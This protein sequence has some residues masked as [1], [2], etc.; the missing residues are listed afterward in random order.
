MPTFLERAKR[1]PLAESRS[2]SAVM[3]RR[4]EGPGAEPILKEDLLRD[5]LNNKDNFSPSGERYNNSDANQFVQEA[6]VQQVMVRAPRWSLDRIRIDGDVKTNY[7][8]RRFAE[9]SRS[10]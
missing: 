2:W 3:A 5:R 1:S 4:P 6:T 8:R 10:N 9:T 7:T